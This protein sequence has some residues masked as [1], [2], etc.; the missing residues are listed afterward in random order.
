MEK[1]HLAGPNKITT[2]YS[3]DEIKDLSHQHHVHI[4]FKWVIILYE[5]G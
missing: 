5:V 4:L 1:P 3:T 2:T